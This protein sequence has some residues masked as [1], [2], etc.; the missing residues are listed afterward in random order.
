V[1]NKERHLTKVLGHGISSTDD[2]LSVVDN[3]VFELLGDDPGYYFKTMKVAG[4]IKDD[5][6]VEKGWFENTHY[7]DTAKGQEVFLNLVN[8]II[9]RRK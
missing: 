6:A 9:L 2:I 1:F 5:P 8:N 3:Q 7:S 4:I